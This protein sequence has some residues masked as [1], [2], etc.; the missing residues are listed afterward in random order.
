ME[1]HEHQQERQ[2]EHEGE[3]ERDAVG[4]DLGH[5]DA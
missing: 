3:D 5:V 4:V 2:P 1:G